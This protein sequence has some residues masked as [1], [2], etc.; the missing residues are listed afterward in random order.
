MW[1]RRSTPAWPGGRAGPTTGPCCRTCSAGRG[2]PRGIWT[3]KID[4]TMSGPA[5]RRTP[6]R[7][8]APCPPCGNCTGGSGPVC[9]WISGWKWRPGVKSSRPPT[10]R[11]TAPSS[12]GI[13]SPSPPAP[14]PPRVCAAA[15]PRPAARPLRPG[16]SRSGWKMA[17]GICRAAPSMSCAARPW[18]PCWKSGRR[19]GP[20]RCSRSGCRPWS[21]AAP[22]PAPA[23]GPV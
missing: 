20:G 14:T 12:T 23:V 15:W 4:G 17:P 8:A 13:P 19:C 21:G 9:R 2:S 18:M 7:P 6:G 1:R 5:A 3:E 16:P 10:G 22:G 11:A